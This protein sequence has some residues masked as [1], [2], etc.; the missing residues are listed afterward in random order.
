ME[1]SQHTD[2]NYMQKRGLFITTIIVILSIISGALGGGASVLYLSR[3]PE[4]AKWFNA[5][6]L[7]GVSKQVTLLEENAVIDVVKKSGPGVV[8]IIV[9]KD[10]NSSQGS[11]SFGF[12]PFSQFFGRV[13][14][15]QNNGQPNIQKVGA[16]SGFFVTSDGLILTNKHVVADEQASYSV[17]TS[18]NKTYEAK[19]VARDP[20]SDLAIVKIDIQNAHALEL[21][22]SSKLSVGQKV[23][24]IGYSLG[25]YQNTVTTG[26]VSGIGRSITA[27]S[28][29]GSETLEGV[30]QTDA[31]INPGN[32]GGPLLNVDGQVIGINTAI[33]REG[34]SVGF[35]IPSN[36]SKTAVDSYKSGGKIS[37]PYLGVRY[38][39]LT[40][41]ISKQKGLSVTKGALI[42]RG[43]TLNETAV[44]SGS[45]ADKA[46][47]VENDVI[48]E[49][50]AEKV[51][52]SRSLAG[53]LK[54][55]KV[56]DIV[57]LRILHDKNEKSVRV[58]LEESK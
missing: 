48:L 36:D 19:V 49:V 57:T 52:D 5:Q 55:K 26:V 38:V 56:G 23:V 15:T 10:L 33:D 11:N 30:I 29:E 42:V 40:D 20:I 13:P 37:R 14:Q 35:A 39:M 50:D 6:N 28:N 27:G 2:A 47:L 7:P 45:P 44:L 21:A 54:N 51:G 8:S 12:D 32:S 1:E 24:A 17:V 25:Q 3:Q 58:T 4:L 9:S 46:G 43:D 34:Q 22:D 53:L 41:E 18:E 16:G 31:A